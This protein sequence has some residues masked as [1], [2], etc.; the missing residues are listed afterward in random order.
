MG[1]G[2]SG[3]VVAAALGGGLLV[4]V[5]LPGAPAT[6]ATGA[7]VAGPQAAVRADAVMPWFLAPSLGQLRSEVNR[8]WPSR[9]RSSDGTIGDLLHRRSRNSHN[10]VGHPYGPVNGTPGAVH[11]IDITAAGIDVDALLRAVIGDSRV[12]YVIYDGRIWS[13]TY[14]WAPG[15]YSG[16]PHRTHIHVSLREESPAAARAAENDTSGWLARVPTGRSSGLDADS[17]RKLQR[18]LISRGFG[19]PAGPTGL[20]GS[21]TRAAVAAFQRS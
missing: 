19:I 12:W 10:P 11:G 16:D 1:I 3:R 13:R 7:P 6:A 20:Y 15:G 5:L 8:R 9:S 2:E 14:N 4:A 17:T 18:A 21:Q